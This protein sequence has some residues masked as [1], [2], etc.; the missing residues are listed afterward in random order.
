MDVLSDCSPQSDL[1]WSLELNHTTLVSSAR[2]EL[3]SQ[4]NLV[5]PRFFFFSISVTD[6]V[7][8]C[9]DGDT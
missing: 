5:F 3:A 1:C 7:L 8:A 9:L 6:G 2:G 4:L